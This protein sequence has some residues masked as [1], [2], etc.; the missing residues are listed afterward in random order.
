MT[1]KFPLWMSL[2][3]IFLLTIQFVNNS[4]S[5]PALEYKPSIIISIMVSNFMMMEFLYKMIS[6]K[7]STTSKRCKILTLIILPM[8]IQYWS[9]S[10]REYLSWQRRNYYCIDCVQKK[11]SFSSP[12]LIEKKNNECILFFSIIC[13]VKRYKIIG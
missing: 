1:V 3:I 2:K 9:V 12:S 11:R 13:R 8:N 7:S 4:S 10:V 6:K 5:N